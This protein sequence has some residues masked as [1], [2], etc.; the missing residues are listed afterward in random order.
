[1]K[2]EK[3]WALSLVKINKRFVKRKRYLQSLHMIFE[4]S[5]SLV[6]IEK[7]IKEE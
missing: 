3:E 6:T 7:C 2:W 5:L 1:V 4:I